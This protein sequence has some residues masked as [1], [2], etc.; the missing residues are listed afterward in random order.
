MNDI[1]QHPRYIELAD[2]IENHYRAAGFLIQELLR[3]F[4]TGN[5]IWQIGQDHRPHLVPMGDFSDPR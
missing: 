3:T 5:N 2:Q 4:P 1:E